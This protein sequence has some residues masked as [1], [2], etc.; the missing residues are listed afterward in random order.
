[1]DSFV[2]VAERHG[3]LTNSHSRS[4]LL[5]RQSQYRGFQQLVK[6]YDKEPNNT[7]RLVELMQDIQEYGQ[8]PPDLIKSIAP[9]LELDADGLPQFNSPG[10]C[11]VM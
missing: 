2:A 9:G 8:P 3:S 4:A 11:C 10:D 7:T 5:S 1:V 6:T